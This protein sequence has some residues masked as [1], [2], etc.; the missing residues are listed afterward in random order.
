MT[1]E[2]IVGAFLDQTLFIQIVI[3]VIVVVEFSDSPVGTTVICLFL[4]RHLTKLL[5]EVAITYSAWMHHTCGILGFRRRD[6][7]CTES[8]C[9]RLDLLLSLGR[10]L[11]SEFLIEVLVDF[12]GTCIGGCG[13]ACHLLAHHL[14]EGT[15]LSTAAPAKLEDSLWLLLL[16]GLFLLL[17]P[18]LVDVGFGQY[19]CFMRLPLNIVKLLERL[20]LVE[21]L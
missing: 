3:F 6:K 7:T 16:L 20:L 17:L 9:L 8:V 14:L 2:V 12:L 10:L 15:A 13:A 19:A 4:C 11:L 21:Y 18:E 1:V 5:T